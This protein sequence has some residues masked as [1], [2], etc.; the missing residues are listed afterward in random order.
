MIPAGLAPDFAT[1]CAA[2]ELS[3]LSNRVFNV[4]GIIGDRFKIEKRK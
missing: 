2:S 3:L 1:G 4:H